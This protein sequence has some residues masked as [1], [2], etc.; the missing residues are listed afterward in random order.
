MVVHTF[1]TSTQEEEAGSL[2]YFKASQ[3]SKVSSRTVRAVRE[4]LSQKTKIIKMMMVMMVKKEE[5][6]EEEK[7]VEIK[8][9]TGVESQKIPAFI[10]Q[11]EGIRITV[12]GLEEMAKWIK[13]ACFRSVRT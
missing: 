10:K 8:R 6:E 1:N 5:E 4:T 11:T 7:K 13:S 9:A 2:Y 3:V 12:V